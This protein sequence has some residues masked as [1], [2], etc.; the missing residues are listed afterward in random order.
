MPNSLLRQEQQDTSG[1]EMWDETWYRAQTLGLN[2]SG[3]TTYGASRRS[4][5]HPS[6]PPP[7]APARINRSR[8]T[9]WARPFRAR[10]STPTDKTPSPSAR[11]RINPGA[12]AVQRR[13]ETPFRARRS[14]SRW[15]VSS[16]P[17]SPP[18]ARARI[19][20]ARDEYPAAPEPASARADHPTRV[21][22]QL[23]ATPPF[24]ALGSTGY[25]PTDVPDPDPTSAHARITRPE[26]YGPPSARADQPAP[27]SSA[28]FRAS[29]R[30]RSAR[31]STPRREPKR[32][33]RRP[34]AA[35]AQNPFPHPRDNPSP[36]L[37]DIGAGTDDDHG[38]GERA[39]D[40]GSSRPGRTTG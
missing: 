39:G 37:S 26:R 13:G 34:H 4:G 20:P 40:N 25:D 17:S 8:S 12:G 6:E 15:S 10:E 38:R 28:S 22:P 3:G 32:V 24:R 30:A 14:T 1:A 33:D 9:G 11:A 36:R 16:T 5:D 19:T 35:I 21:P 27:A 2:G 7:S 23:P 18:S 29:R 31:G